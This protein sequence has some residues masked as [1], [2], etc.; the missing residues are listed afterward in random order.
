[1]KLS[2]FLPQPRELPARK[3]PKC[4]PGSTFIKDFLDWP[5]EFPKPKISLR[6]AA[7]IG[8]DETLMVGLGMAS[9]LRFPTPGFRQRCADE[10]KD[11]LGF[12]EDKGWL[13]NP[14]GYHQAPPKLNK[15]Q[16]KK[17]T[18][19]GVDY[20]HMTFES[21]YVPHMGEA[22][23][24][25]WLSYTPNH[26][27]HCWVLRHS[28]PAR[29]WLINIHGYRMGM[30]C[31]DLPCFHAGALHESKGLNILQYVLPLHGPRK[32]G[33]TSGD[34]V[35]SPGYVNLIHTQAQAMFEL[36]RIITWLK[37]EQEAQEVGV[38]GISL[39]GYTTALLSGLQGGL[40]CAIAGVPAVNLVRAA[41]RLGQRNLLYFMDNIGM[42]WD[43][44]EKMTQVISP[45]AL[46]PK[47]A[48][49]KR[50]I[51]AGLFDRL[52]RPGDPLGL[53]RHWGQ[54]KIEWYHGNHISFPWEKRVNRFIDAA[55]NESFTGLTPLVTSSE[56]G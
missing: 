45:T 49:K 44:I 50:Y 11:T 1:M 55:L 4:I 43:D 23:R 29:P 48:L 18:S 10:M 41:R 8:V 7:M 56:E 14:R 40:A 51:Y 37:K 36:R 47:I 42:P 13:E 6:S 22:G 5:D 31:M 32:I 26:T 35:L 3:I 28:G 33:P 25:R 39:G 17:E 9:R 38:H 21:G 20:E 15:T 34:G 52:A 53:W 12:F 16:F 27:A 2:S 24:N 19:L 54:P 46:K 30:P